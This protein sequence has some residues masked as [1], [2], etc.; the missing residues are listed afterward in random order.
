M[1]VIS[2]GSSFYDVPVKRL[3]AYQ[4]QETLAAAHISKTELAARLH[5]SR[6]ALDRLLDPDNDSAT[7]Q[8]LKRVAAALG[9]KLRLELV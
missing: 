2:T 6:A 3:F 7:I 9:K 5:T 4:L 8:S 1:K